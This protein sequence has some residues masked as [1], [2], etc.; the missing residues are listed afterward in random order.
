MVVA[1]LTQWIDQEY[2]HAKKNDLLPADWSEQWAKMK[3][4]QRLQKS[5]GHFRFGLVDLIDE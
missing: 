2:E 1:G 4:A 5:I 3:I